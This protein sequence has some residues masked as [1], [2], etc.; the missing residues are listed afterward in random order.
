MNRLSRDVALKPVANGDSAPGSLSAE[1]HLA[2]SLSAG[3]RSAGPPPSGSL[4]PVPRPPAWR[5]FLRRALAAV[6]PFLRAPA[7][8]TRAFLT[9]ELRNAL[10]EIAKAQAFAAEE[11]RQALRRG[12]D[13][14]GTAS[15]PA[16]GAAPQAP[17]RRTVHQFHSGSAPGDGVTNAMLLLRRVLRDLGYRSEIFVEFRDPALEGELRTIDDLPISEDYVLVVHHSMGHD[18]FARLAALPAPKILVYHNITPPALLADVPWAQAYAAKGREQLGLWRPHIA[19]ALADSAFNLLDLKAEGYGVA[20]ECPILFDVTA[21]ERRAAAQAV[22]ACAGKPFTIL[23]VGRVVAAKGQA[24]LVDAFAAFR[25]NFAAPCRLVLVGRCEPGGEGYTAEVQARI[26]RHRL[27]DAVVLSGWLEDA[28]LDAW[29]AEADL[30]VSLSAHEGFG[31]PL[32]EAMA[33]GVPVL[34]WPAGAVPYTLGTAGRL[35]AERSAPEVAAAMLHLARDPGA[36]REQAA[37]QKAALGRFRLERALPRLVA[38]LAA[39]GARPPVDVDTQSLVA[40]H[41]RFAVSGHIN[42]TYSLAAINRTLALAIEEARPGAVRVLAVE[43]VPTGRLD[44]VPAIEREAM[45]RLAARP[46]PPSGPEV[47]ISQHFPIHVPAGDFDLRLG[48]VFWEETLLPPAMIATLV[49]GFQGV[50]APSRF[51]AKALID[52]GLSIPVRTVGAAP[53]I[54]RFAAL[55]ADRVAGPPRAAGT[56]TFLHVSSCFPRKGA[57]LLLASYARAFRLTDPV[58]LVI[59]TFPNPH[60]E[61]ERQIADLRARVPECPEIVLINRDVAEEEMLALYAEA[62]AMVLP[63]RG[64]GFNL[65]A[66]EAMAAGIPLIVTGF[67]GHQDFCGGAEARLISWRFGPAASHVSVPHGLWAEPDEDDL[68]AALR[69]IRDPACREAI[70]RRTAAARRAAARAA[71]R[72]AWTDRIAAAATAL[73]LDPGPY[74]FRTAWVSS[75]DVP[76]GIAAYSESLLQRSRFW[77]EDTVI[78]CDDRTPVAVPGRGRPGVRIAWRAGVAESMAELARA[79]S[80]ED[81][82]AVFVSHQPG[83]ISWPALRALLTDPR[84]GGRTVVVL[85][86][87]LEDFFSLPEAEL[88]GLIAALAGA[89]RV[90]VHRLSDMNRLGAGARRLENLALLPL[91]AD[92]PDAAP[93]ARALAPGDDVLIGCHGFFLPHKG[94]ADLIAASARLAEGWPGLRLRLVNARYPNPE[95]AS[96]IVRCRALAEELGVAGRIEWLTDFLPRERIGALLRGCDLIALPYR[97]SEDSASAALRV[98]L[99][100]LVPVA[101]T[102]VPLFEEA[103]GA[104]GW[105]TPEDPAR[106]ADELA[107]LLGATERRRLL[108]AAAAEWLAAR[109]RGRTAERLHGMIGGLVA[110]RS[111]RSA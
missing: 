22:P 41:L 93:F 18:A 32:V 29:Y 107:A 110:E 104:V 88:A 30:Y 61:I 109:D 68:V 17:W 11:V 71:D 99:A 65:P 38:A 103:G 53:D 23:F 12:F 33:F 3:P 9:I 36:R 94:I 97:Q 19:A 34:A 83:L 66:L 100:S 31:I 67:G 69:E 14:V 50:L 16:A 108:Q 43:G 80:R 59:K 89:A 39:A 15:R 45:V 26:A 79:I 48:L 95:S 42:K 84:L 8:R 72:A 91:G 98:A 87:S 10:E 102:R 40:A 44:E 78:L 73:L 60:H 49:G 4:P 25:T 76:C 85:L 21:L 7:R 57:D 77:S 35:L 27:G 20:V 105:L 106:L 101:A 64:E 56:T 92:A 63:T 2:G 62:D 5:R 47:A 86:H 6:R 55:G 111:A 96:E 74:R 82:E 46:A 51:V 75:W 24:D 1:P 13:S 37:R 90:L 52:S 70:A 81:P 54:A 58:R 28:A